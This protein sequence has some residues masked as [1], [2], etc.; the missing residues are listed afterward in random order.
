[1]TPRRA[2]VVLIALLCCGCSTMVEH[3]RTALHELK[4]HRLWRWNRHPAPRGDVYFS[5][6]DPVAE[7]NAGRSMLHEDGP[8]SASIPAN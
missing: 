3:S 8:D 1:M 6:S 4:P 7:S 5:I 2:G